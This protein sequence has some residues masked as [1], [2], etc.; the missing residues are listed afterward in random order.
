[1]TNASGDEAARSPAANLV[2]V[3]D[4]DEHARFI[5]RS[6][7]QHAGFDVIT[8]GDGETALA[9]CAASPPGSIVIDI[10][11]PTCASLDVVRALARHAPFRGA[12]VATT[13]RAMV[14]EQR[15]LGT[16]GLRAILV[17]P[18]D[19]KTVLQAVCGS[20]GGSD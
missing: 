19:P 17:K 12:I 8:A 11:P 20:F 3:V 9:L 5:F 13:R 1:M 2:L 7:L 6:I 16:L 14:H 10:D 18:V 4:G 15:A